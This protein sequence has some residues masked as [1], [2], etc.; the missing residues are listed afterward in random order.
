V[1][2]EVDCGTHYDAMVARGL[3]YRGAFRC[4]ETIWRGERRALG[5]IKFPDEF[6][7]ELRGYEIH[8]TLLDAG[9]QIVSATLPPSRGD[10]YLPSSV[11]G[12]TVY[13]GLPE[14]VW[15]QVE[16]VGDS[17]AGADELEAHIAFFSSSGELVAEV[18]QLG[19]KQL[20][21]VNGSDSSEARDSLYEVRWLQMPSPEVEGQS[22][23]GRFLILADRGGIG[24]ALSVEL[25]R[26]DQESRVVF[27]E[28]RSGIEAIV[29]EAALSERTPLL[30]VIH[31]WGLDCGELQ[32]VE[33]LDRA[34]EL[35]PL[36]IL[37]T[38][39][40]LIASGNAK[41]KLWCVTQNGQRP[42]EGPN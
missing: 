20:E 41:T 34:N 40:G 15:C 5:L 12:L 35:G 6:G 25:G 33:S 29:R 26:L 8:P 42:V 36:S 28:N 23:S 3:N 13:G 17:T 19:L 1:S 10:T 16:L 2:D 32:G 4:V 37:A 31:L 30:G 14:S 38:L 24:E 18:E 22:V 39:R 21:A 9:F 7:S 27:S 11:K